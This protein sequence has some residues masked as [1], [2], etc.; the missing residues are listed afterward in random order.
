MSWKNLY[1]YLYHPS[2]PHLVLVC[3]L[4]AELSI[5]NRKVKWDDI[6]LYLMKI[7]NSTINCWKLHKTILNSSVVCKIA[8][9][10][11][12]N[13][14]RWPRIGTDFL[15]ALPFNRLSWVIK[16]YHHLFPLNGPVSM[17]TEDK[18]VKMA[19]Q[20]LFENMS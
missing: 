6:W 18:D 8:L 14:I 5:I 3:F 9:L 11:K 13:S 17:V 4:E 20:Y 2:E 15:H 12:I 1:I 10:I 19:F 7:Y 16:A